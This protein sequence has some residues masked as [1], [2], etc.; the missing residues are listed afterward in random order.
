MM[1]RHPL[2]AVAPGLNRPYEESVMRNFTTRDP[3]ADGGYPI[4]S[5]LHQ[6]SDDGGPVGPDPARWADPDW[7]DNLG[8]MDTF[9]DGVRMGFPDASRPGAGTVTVHRPPGPAVRNPSQVS[10]RAVDPGDQ[11][12]DTAR[13]PSWSSVRVEGDPMALWTAHRS[14]DGGALDF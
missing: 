1:Y 6:M 13:E 12:D 10:R 11:P 8:V 4:D 5:D 7:R 2:A 9:E 3:P 14:R